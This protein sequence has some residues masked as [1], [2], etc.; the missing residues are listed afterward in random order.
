MVD[1]LLVN[2]K[3]FKFRKPQKYGEFFFH[4]KHIY[5]EFYI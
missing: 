1:L 2:I 5:F 3:K 4:I